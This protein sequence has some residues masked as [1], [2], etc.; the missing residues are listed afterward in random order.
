MEAN[1]TPLPESGFATLFRNMVVMANIDEIRRE[2]SQ[3][4]VA[5]SRTDELL[6]RRGHLVEEARAAGMTYREVAQ[7]LGMT[8]TG[9]RKTQK[10]F[11]ARSTQLEARAS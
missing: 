9:L 7:L 10:A 2:I 5:I 1:D 6:E 11:R 8:E 3:V 4:G